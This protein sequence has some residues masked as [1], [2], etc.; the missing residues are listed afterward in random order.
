[1][2]LLPLNVSVLTL[3][4]EVISATASPSGSPRSRPRSPMGEIPDWRV[5]S[6]SDDDAER[7]SGDD[8]DDYVKPELLILS[9]LKRAMAEENKPK[10][11]L[12]VATDDNRSPLGGEEGADQNPHNYESEFVARPNS[13]T[14]KVVHYEDRDHDSHRS[15]SERMIIL[16]Q[17]LMQ[18][19]ST[20]RNQGR[21]K[22]AEELDV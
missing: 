12:S 15:T 1:M 11:S 10:S 7:F 6:E 9:L 21:W 17:K 14:G 22:E 5:D 3:T 13:S 16:S 4:R 8:D 18:R 2:G 19:A 20:Y